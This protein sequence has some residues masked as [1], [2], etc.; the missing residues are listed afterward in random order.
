MKRFFLFFLFPLCI[1]TGIS[2]CSS[3]RQPIKIGL[4]IN[5]SGRGGAAGEHI[6]N[7]AMLAVEEIHNNGGVRGRPLELLVQDD[8]NSEAGIRRAD[9]AL[10]D[11]KVAV[12]F[13][14]SYSANTLKAYPLVTGRDTLLVTA[15]TATTKLSGKDD[16]F[17]RTSVD[18]ALY[19]RKLASLLDRR[20]IPSIAVLMDMSNPGFVIDYLEQL[21][22]HYRGTIATA[23][24][25]S[26]RN[27]DWSSL[28][29]SLL[30]SEPAAVLLLTEASMGGIAAQ[31]LRGRAFQG[32]L[33]AT[34]WV[35]TPEL[36][37][38]GGPAVEGMSIV[39]FIDPDN[40]RPEFQNFSR[41]M[42]NRFNQT[43][44]ARSSRACEMIH[45]LAD[46]LERCPTITT[47]NLK[48]A[49]LA[50]E[51]QTLMGRVRFDRFG[52]VDRPIYEVVVRNGAFHT[53][54][55]L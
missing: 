50:G 35:Q 10:L 14:H 38:A 17:L 1:I 54:G 37:R 55:E 48:T 4:A 3:P 41:K 6:R 7:G 45:I 33:L 30:S 32:P 8:E 44:T 49:L 24:F 5:L 28:I 25:E 23:S 46:A 42:K 2:H 11:E 34:L 18:C 51:Y 26:R 9:E 31:K 12:I 19:G 53:V 21:R 27:A 29:E 13:G 39:T 15:Y 47:A 40:N 52:D 36:F 20:Q 16:L 22:K 43:A